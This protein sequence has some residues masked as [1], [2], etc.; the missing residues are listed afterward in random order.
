MLR[1]CGGGIGSSSR[2]K[3]GDGTKVG[4]G[5]GVQVAG[6][7]PTETSRN[8]DARASAFRPVFTAVIPYTHS[9]PL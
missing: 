3:V 8:C 4:V 7:S 1:Y 2:V 6:K 9:V 5:V